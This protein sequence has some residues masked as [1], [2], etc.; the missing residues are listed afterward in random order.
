M[1][2]ITLTLELAFRPISISIAFSFPYEKFLSL[3]SSLTF[4]MHADSALKFAGTFKLLLAWSLVIG[5]KKVG[6][7][8]LLWDIGFAGSFGKHTFSTIGVWLLW[9][10]NVALTFRHENLLRGQ[11]RLR[12]TLGSFGLRRR[13]RGHDIFVLTTIFARTF[14]TVCTAG[15]AL[16]ASIAAV[17]TLR[18]PR[19]ARKGVIIPDAGEAAS[20]LSER[21]WRR[22]WGAS[23]AIGQGKRPLGA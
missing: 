22:F 23:Q 18:R 15:A 17:T 13:G 6:R 12:L 5:I 14:T 19:A 8:W 7:G 2:I 11:V 1:I 3:P 4:L 21:L 10:V 9:A 16:T 20:R